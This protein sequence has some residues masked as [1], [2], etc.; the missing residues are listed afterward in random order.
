MALNVPAASD[1][2]S[3]NAATTSGKHLRVRIA[4]E[5]VSALQASL[6]VGIAS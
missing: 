2:T 6:K 5:L 3:D 4:D 1:P